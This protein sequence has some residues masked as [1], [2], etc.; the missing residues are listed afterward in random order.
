MVSEQFRS[1]GIQY[2]QILN[3]FD[4]SELIRIVTKEIT[5]EE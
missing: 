5:K 4:Q 1:E 2:S 3:K